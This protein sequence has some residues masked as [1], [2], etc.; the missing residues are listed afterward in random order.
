V[1][2]GFTAGSL[3][4]KGASDGMRRTNN[5][6]SSDKE[7]TEFG[8]ITEGGQWGVGRR[9]RVKGSDKTMW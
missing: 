6:V 8:R 1:W 5:K 4:R 7:L 3:S 9:L 2:A